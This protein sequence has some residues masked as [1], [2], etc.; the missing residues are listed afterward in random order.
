MHLYILII[1]LLSFLEARW[2]E[3]VYVRNTRKRQLASGFTKKPEIKGE[4]SDY[5]KADLCRSIQ[6]HQVLHGGARIEEMNHHLGV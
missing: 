5:R 6:I 2:R 1:S 3:E 4:L